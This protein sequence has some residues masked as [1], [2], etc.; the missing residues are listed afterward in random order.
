MVSPAE[1]ARNVRVVSASNL[2]T[3]TYNN[4]LQVVLQPIVIYLTW[5]VVLL[6]A[7]QAVATRLGGLLYASFGFTRCPC[8]RASLA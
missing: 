3:G 1:G 2:L 6:G 7:L 4:L 8:S 5:S